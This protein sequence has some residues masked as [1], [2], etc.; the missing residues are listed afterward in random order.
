MT[1]NKQFWIFLI[2]LRI[3]CLLLASLDILTRYG[4]EFFFFSESWKNFCSVSNRWKIYVHQIHK[5]QKVGGLPGWGPWLRYQRSCLLF[6]QQCSYGT[7][8]FL[9]VQVLFQGSISNVFNFLHFNASS[10]SCMNAVTIL[11]KALALSCGYRNQN[12]YIPVQ[13]RAVIK[14]FPAIRGLIY[15]KSRREKEFC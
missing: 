2:I 14:V 8:I 3:L 1:L 11:L 13:L 12:K 7:K 4:A 9:F 5:T 15:D 6:G 10:I